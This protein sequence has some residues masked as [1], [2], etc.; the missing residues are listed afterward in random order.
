[1]GRIRPNATSTDEIRRCSELESVYTHL[2]L[3]QPFYIKPKKE[4]R[5]FSKAARRASTELYMSIS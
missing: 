5:R 3:L 1:M 2:E 4:S